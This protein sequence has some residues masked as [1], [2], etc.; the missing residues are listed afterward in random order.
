MIKRTHHCGQLGVELAGKQV[1]LK[2]WVQRRRDLGQVIFLDVRDR[3]GIVQTVCSPDISKSA[4]GAADKIRN[5]YIVAIKG[6]VVERSA[7]AVNEKLATG[8]SK[9]M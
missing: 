4:L 2:G 8:Q 3:S 5:E 7:N 1:E 6:T 9:F